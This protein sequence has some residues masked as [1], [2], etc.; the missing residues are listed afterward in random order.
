MVSYAKKG[1]FPL[2]I[3]CCILAPL[4]MGCRMLKF[5]LEEVAIG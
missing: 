3:K 2:G 5:Q 4:T 1:I